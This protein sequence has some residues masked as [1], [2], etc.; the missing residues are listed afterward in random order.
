M[1]AGCAS[2]DRASRQLAAFD[3]VLARELQ[4]RFDRLGSAAQEIGLRDSGR[5]FRDERVCQRLRRHVR[6]RRAVD[7]RERRGL[8]ADSV[9]DLAHAVADVGDHRAA[10][11]IQITL[12][13]FIEE[14]HALAT[15]DERRRAL[16]LAIENVTVAG[17]APVVHTNS[18]PFAE[19]G[20][21]LVSA[22]GGFAACGNARS[23]RSASAHTAGT[24]SAFTAIAIVSK[25]TGVDP[26]SAM[27]PA[28]TTTAALKYENSRY[29]PIAIR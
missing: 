21:L 3:V 7:V 11:R 22:A 15:H 29:C 27:Q 4:R 2:D 19:E 6:E 24:S 28:S 16:Q 18:G 17:R 13:V 20:S 26:N 14:I 8:Y 23:D 25:R 10:T 12:A 9:P 5:R 1:I